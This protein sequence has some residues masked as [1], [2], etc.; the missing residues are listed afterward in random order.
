MRIN[1]WILH[2]NT[3]HAVGIKNM[4]EWTY[5]KIF[6]NWWATV[7]LSVNSVLSQLLPKNAC[8]YIQ[9]SLK[10]VGSKKLLE[11]SKSV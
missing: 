6:V 1:Y 11:Q 4:F 3:L 7:N 10:K 5:I 9:K 2:C 8:H